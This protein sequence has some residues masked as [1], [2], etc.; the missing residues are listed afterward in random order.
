MIGGRDIVI[1][2]RARANA[3][4]VAIRLA[5]RI[6]PK[7]ICED[8][9]T[10]TRYQPCADLPFGL[11]NEVLIYRDSSVAQQWDELGA[12][13]S[14]NDTLIHLL[15]QNEALTVVVDSEPSGQMDR[16]VQALCEALRQEVFPLSAP[17]V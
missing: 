12:D 9:K 3:L 10:G 17:S 6:W 13:P 4:D 11:T 7:A 5:T 2:T 15:I 8:A 1:P 16:Y 14:L